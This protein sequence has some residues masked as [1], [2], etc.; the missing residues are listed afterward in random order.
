MSQTIHMNTWQTKFC[1]WPRSFGHPYPHTV[2][3]RKWRCE[4]LH[5]DNVRAWR[6]P[7]SHERIFFAFLMNVCRGRIDTPSL[8]TGAHDMAA[9]DQAV[10]QENWLLTCSTALFSYL[11]QR[12]GVQHGLRY[13]WCAKDFQWVFSQHVKVY[14]STKRTLNKATKYGTSSYAPK[15]CQQL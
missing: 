8:C 11:L 14:T 7:S 2:L 12:N 10:C 3:P 6:L 4:N 1:R 13:Q 15:W 5:L 9:V